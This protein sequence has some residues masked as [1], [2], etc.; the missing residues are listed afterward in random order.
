M[1]N[2]EML[3]ALPA[4]EQGTGLVAVVAS[5]VR[6][7]KAQKEFLSLTLGDKTGTLPAKIW[8]WHG[9]TP[10]VGEIWK[11]QVES[12]PYN[13]AAQC[14]IRDWTVITDH[15]SVDKGQFIAALSVEEFAY[16]RDE[17]GKLIDQIKNPELKQFI[18]KTI[19]TYPA[20]M[21]HPGAQ[22]IHHARLGGLLEHTVHVTK[23]ALAMAYSYKGTPKWDMINT[24]LLIAGGIVHDLGKILDYTTDSYVIDS[25]MEIAL[26]G[27]HGL[28]TALLMNVW[29][30]SDEIISWSTLVGLMHMQLS[31]HG[32]NYAPMLS[33]ITFSAWL[34]HGADM[35]D[36]KTDAI[37][38]H[39]D[40]EVTMS[41]DKC[42]AVGSR[43]VDER[44]L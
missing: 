18:I 1:M 11:V 27:Q 21:N 44:K 12:S 9:D 43:V 32:P 14:V 3:K 24:D 20:F 15:T 39:L 4:K 28:N 22:G 17:L 25:T 34:L 37:C 35:A 29:K 16:Y 5:E 2:V 26:T 23:S 40:G 36:A 30:E 19:A 7:T 10:K 6:K 31:H 38:G 8:D 42:F 41:R 13:G 33:P